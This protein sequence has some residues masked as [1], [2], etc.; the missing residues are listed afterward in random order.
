MIVAI[1]HRGDLH[2]PPV[3]AALRRLGRAAVLLDLAEFPRRGRIALGYGPGRRERVLHTPAGAIRAR[4]VSAG[5]RPCGR[6]GDRR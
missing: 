4:D 3:L 6:S 1:S 2:A 5:L